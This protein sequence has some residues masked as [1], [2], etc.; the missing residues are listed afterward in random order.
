LAEP[1]IQWL[2][3]DLLPAKVLLVLAVVGIYLTIT[4]RNREKKQA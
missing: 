1:S 3:E 2:F 4:E